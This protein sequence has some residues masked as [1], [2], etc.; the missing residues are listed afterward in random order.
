MIRNIISVSRYSLNDRET[1]LNL[2]R[3]NTPKYFAPDEERDFENYL[4]N[5]I[6]D[7]FTISVKNEIVGC[8]G[9]NFE[10]EKT[11]GII[12]WDIIHPDYQGKALGSYLLKY[13]IEILKAIQSVQQIIVRTSQS[14]YLFY[15]KHGFQVKKIVPDFWADGFDLY[16]MEYRLEQLRG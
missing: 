15:Q 7:Y 10:N 6:E 16:L 9:I 12:S 4:Q 1:L 11:I 2:V 8:G 13:R 5:E 3:L 14:T